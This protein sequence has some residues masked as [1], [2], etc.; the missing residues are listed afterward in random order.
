MSGPKS[1][2]R[3][4]TSNS[5]GA[6]LEPLRKLLLLGC[7]AT[8]LTPAEGTPPHTP[9]PCTHRRVLEKM[10]VSPTGDYISKG[11]GGTLSG[12]MEMFSILHLD[13]GM[14]TWGIHVSKVI[15]LFN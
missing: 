3:K 10:P 12:E 1:R 2:Y 5:L 13:W 8:I 6:S 15:N 11:A 4:A 14:V 9:S 7:N